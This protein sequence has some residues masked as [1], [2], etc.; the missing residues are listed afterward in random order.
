MSI[1]PKNMGQVE[2]FFFIKSSETSRKHK[3]SHREIVPKKIIKGTGG[4]I[5]MPADVNESVFKKQLDA[6]V[7]RKEINIGQFIVR[8]K[9]EKL[10]LKNSDLIKEYFSVY[11]GEIK[12]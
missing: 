11:G 3:I 2:K 1:S 8:K 5:S 6:I 4:E 7:E 10:I 12:L 9:V